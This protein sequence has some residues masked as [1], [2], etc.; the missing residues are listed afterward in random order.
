MLDDLGSQGYGAHFRVLNRA[1]A[2]F[3]IYEGN[4][5]HLPQRPQGFNL[6]EIDQW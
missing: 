2:I 3:Q 4:H 1:R 6:Q 5:A